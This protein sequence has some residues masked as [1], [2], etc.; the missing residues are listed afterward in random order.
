MTVFF[1]NFTKKPGIH[2]KNNMIENKINELCQVEIF[3]KVFAIIGNI[4]I[5]NP[6]QAVTI[7]AA[8]LLF[9]FG[10]CFEIIGVKI[11]PAAPAKPKPT[12]RPRFI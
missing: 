11:V 10:K 6:P 12:S 4:N 9:S 2:I 8:L 3:L 5:P 7:P 1:G